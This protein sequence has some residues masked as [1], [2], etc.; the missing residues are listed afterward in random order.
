MRTRLRSTVIAAAV[1]LTG[2]FASSAAAQGPDLGAV[3]FQGDLSANGTITSGGVTA[4]VGPYKADLQGFGTLF[5]D[6]TNA[7]I[8]CVDWSHVAPARGAW[9]SYYATWLGQSD[10]SRTREN[11]DLGGNQVLARQRYL[12]AAWIIEQHD[13]GVAAFTSAVHVQGTLWELFSGS[14]FN[15]GAGAYADLFHLVP[16]QFTLQRDWFV[17]SDDVLQCGSTAGCES[18]Q[19]FLY[20]RERPTTVPEPG[21]YAL[22]ATGLAGLLVATRRRRARA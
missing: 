6:V 22:M 1:V 12:Q 9:D 5:P 17:L 15:P 21:T 11:F 19:E 13:A 10:M 18:N 8:W 3:R 7:I 4:L 16:Q 14:A 2:A 20:W